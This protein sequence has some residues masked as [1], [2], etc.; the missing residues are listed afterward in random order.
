[1]TTFRTMSLTRL[2]GYCTAV[3]AIGTLLSFAYDSNAWSADLKELS[4]RQESNMLSM[5]SRFIARQIMQWS[6]KPANT[7]QEKQ[8]KN[9]MIHQLNTDKK[10]IVDK[11]RVIDDN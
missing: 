7:E 5:E 6:V 9:A 10:E 4:N 3:I 8:Y 11:L 1:M 2:G